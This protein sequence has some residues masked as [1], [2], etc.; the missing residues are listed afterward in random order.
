MLDDVSLSDTAWIF[1]SDNP[2]TASLDWDMTLSKI[3]EN[4]MSY[5]MKSVMAR[6]WIFI[7]MLAAFG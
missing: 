7:L 6:M 1:G 3:K 5:T 2:T 4:V